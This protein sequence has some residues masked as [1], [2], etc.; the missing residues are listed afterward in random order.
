MRRVALLLSLL[1]AGCGYTAGA[2]VPGDGRT[3]AVPVFVNETFRRDLERDLTRHV[4]EEI[5]SHS[6]F[7]LVD[8]SSRP[9]LVLEGSL[10]DVSENVLSERSAG[11]IR[12]SSVT[13]TVSV[14]VVDTRT[15]EAAVGPVTIRERKAFTPL[16]D[17][18]I[19]TAEA[20][21][22]R[23][24]ASRIVYTLARDW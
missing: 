5:R 9:D 10:I 19:R 8:V 22:M 20:A 7:R 17:E 24:I 13:L 23:K 21:A 15:G 3:I 18:S 11:E 1:S 14:K 6:T 4:A 2:V 16:K 12:E